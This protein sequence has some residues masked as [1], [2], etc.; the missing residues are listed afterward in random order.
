MHSV[1][2]TQV[3]SEGY[4]GIGNFFRHFE[5]GTT[6]KSPCFKPDHYFYEMERGGSVYIM[7]NQHNTV[8]YTGVT[9]NLYSRVYEHKNKL[10]PKSFTA[11]YN[12][13]KL[14]YFEHLPTI[15]EAITRE[16]QIK[17]FGRRKKSILI[18]IINPNWDD[19]HDSLD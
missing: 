18:N 15:E 12:I 11:K 3:I 14:V 5:G 9:S 1:G 6:E 4:I 8:L 16:K 19:L 2:E 13:I 7:T 17:K 10:Y